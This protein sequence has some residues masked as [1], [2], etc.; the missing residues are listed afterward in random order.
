MPHTGNTSPEND[1]NDSD[2]DSNSSHDRNYYP[3]PGNL[4]SPDSGKQKP[5]K[6]L[7]RINSLITNHDIATAEL[8]NLQVID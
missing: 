3:G 8:G 7:M 5:P 4:L 6:K 2:E 1:M